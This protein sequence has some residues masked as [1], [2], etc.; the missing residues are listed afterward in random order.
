M[1]QNTTE[2]CPRSALHA[3]FLQILPRIETHARIHFRHLRCPGK[4]DD[5]IAEVVAVTWKWF[6]RIVEQQ[7][8]V[9]EMARKADGQQ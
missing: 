5:A 8:N 7:K 2:R 1:L 3:H 9:D 6:L 4:R